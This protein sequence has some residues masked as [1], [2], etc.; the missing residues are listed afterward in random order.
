MKTDQLS[1]GIF[2]SINQFL[3]PNQLKTL[4]V[5]VVLLLKMITQL[6][7]DGEMVLSDAMKQQEE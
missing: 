5:Q 6:L 2:L 4:E 1:C 3:L 7:Q